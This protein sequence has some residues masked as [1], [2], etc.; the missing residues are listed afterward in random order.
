MPDRCS[1]LDLRD[2]TPADQPFLDA[3]YRSVREDLTC[4]GNNPAIDALITMQQNIHEHGHR[5][6]YPNARNLLLA[7]DGRST[8]RLVLDTNQ[9]RLHIVDITV[10]TDER[11]QG[12]G[13]ALL[14]WA[15]QQATTAQVPL[16]LR[17]QRHNL[18]ALCLYQALGFVTVAGDELSVLMCWQG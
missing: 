14:R 1:P 12:T 16:E 11:S 5:S 2:A 10:L 15:Q 13:T 17:V 18:R 6:H 4:L 9:Q 8:A 3:L 7:R